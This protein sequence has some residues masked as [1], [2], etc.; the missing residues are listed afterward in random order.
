MGDVG[1]AALAANARRVPRLEELDMSY[2]QITAV[3]MKRL[4]ASKVFANLTRLRIGNPFGPEGVRYLA[5]CRHLKRLTTLELHGA[6][7]GD[8]GAEALARSPHLAKLEEL[9]L[10]ETGIGPDGALAIAASPYLGGL[11]LLEVRGNPLDAASRCALKDRF[12]RRA[13]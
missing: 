13:F 6:E 4:A 1:A 3:G 7:V 12:G 8:E 9:R 2:N 10:G 5:K 11:K